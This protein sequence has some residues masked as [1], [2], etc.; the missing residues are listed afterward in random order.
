MTETLL[1][2]FDVEPTL[3]AMRMNDLL[4]YRWPAGFREAHQRWAESLQEPPTMPPTWFFDL[5]DEPGPVE[6]Q[7]EHDL[8]ELLDEYHINVVTGAGLKLYHTSHWLLL[9]ASLTRRALGTPLAEHT[10]A[11][12]RQLSLHFGSR[13]GLALIPSRLRR[14]LMVSERRSSPYPVFLRS[15]RAALGTPARTIEPEAK[16]HLLS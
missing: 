6:W 16:W 8:Q 15:L 10:L 9:D 13:P 14:Q 11:M 12:A 5:T 3:T 1:A 4:E 2:M 7:E